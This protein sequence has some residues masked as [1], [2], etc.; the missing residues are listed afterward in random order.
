MILDGSDVVAE[1]S[2]QQFEIERTVFEAGLTRLAWLIV[3]WQ[4]LG[5]IIASLGAGR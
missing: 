2:R 5:I 1:R 4:T 3:L